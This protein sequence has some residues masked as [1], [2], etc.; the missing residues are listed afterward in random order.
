MVLL[1]IS[2]PLAQLC[3]LMSKLCA[4]LAGSTVGVEMCKADIEAS[5]GQM[6]AIMACLE[7]FT[8]LK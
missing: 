7:P 4:M 2:E 8:L 5:H 6:V 1:A 3:G